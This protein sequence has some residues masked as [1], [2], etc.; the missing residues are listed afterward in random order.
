MPQS[1]DQAKK[2]TA[3]LAVLV[4]RKLISGPQADIAM[5]DAEVTGM[6][7][8]E[9]LLAR[10]WVGEDML[11]SLAPWLRPGGQ[12]VAVEQSNK[13]G[14]AVTPSQTHAETSAR[15]RDKIS[16][17]DI[18]SSEDFDENLQKY[19]SIMDGILGDANK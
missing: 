18:A 3:L 17:E 19:R 15:E 13:A 11:F 2:L 10:R 6:T 5:A 12:Q 1:P 8:D 9:V 4:E 7:L 16:S 14:S